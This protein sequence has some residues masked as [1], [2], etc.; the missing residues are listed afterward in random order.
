MMLLAKARRALERYPLVAAEVALVCLALLLRRHFLLTIV[1][2]ESMLPTIK[3]GQVLLVDKRAYDSAQP[4]RGDIVVARY[5]QDL[6]V[7]RVV[8]LPGEEV[9]VKRALHRWRCK[10]RETWHHDG[11]SRCR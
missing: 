4:H 7:K 11:V 2:G 10:N 8:G 1:L 9:E 6:I 5:G 3:P